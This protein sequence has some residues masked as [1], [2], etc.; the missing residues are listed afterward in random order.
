[1]SSSVTLT[2][3]SSTSANNQVG[4]K[5]SSKPGGGGAGGGWTQ[6]QF[7]THSSPSGALPSANGLGFDQPPLT[8]TNVVNVTNIAAGGGGSPG[9][10]IWKL[11]DIVFEFYCYL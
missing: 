3:T 2:T 11:F 7:T 10:C 6:Q 4:N 1:M 5:S 8:S 9:A